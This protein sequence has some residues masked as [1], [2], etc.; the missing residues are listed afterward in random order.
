M[1][2][3]VAGALHLDVVLRAPRLP[4]LDETVVGSAVDYVFG[5]KGGNQAVA[6]S[7]MGSDVAFAGRIG[8]DGFGRIVRDALVAADIDVSQ[9]QSDSGASGMS[10]AIVEDSGEY[11]AVIVSA[12]NQRIDPDAIHIP[13]GTKLVLLQNEI[14]EEVNLS[15]AGKARQAGAEVW[16]NAAPARSLPPQLAETLDLIIVNRVEAEFYAGSLPKTRMLKTLGAE[17]VLVDGVAFPACAVDTVSSHGA[18]D[19]FVGALAARVA[20]GEALT[21]ALPF[22]QAAAALHVSTPVVERGDITPSRVRDFLADQ[23]SR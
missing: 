11:G 1:T 6:A 20:S 3:F 14:R 18:G 2:V 12:A 19:M 22:A 13:K 4:A 21:D 5:G 7:R 16:L 9:L 23:S 10:A 15:V 17:G 8:S